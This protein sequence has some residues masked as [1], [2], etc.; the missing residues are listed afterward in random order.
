MNWETPGEEKKPRA[1]RM[2]DG[3]NCYGPVYPC[4]CV[5]VFTILSY[6]GNQFGLVGLFI[7]PEQQIYIL[8]YNI[9]FHQQAT[10]L[11]KQLTLCG[12]TEGVW[13]SHRDQCLVLF[14]LIAWRIH[15]GEIGEINTTSSDNISLAFPQLS[16]G[17]KTQP[18]QQQT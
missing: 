9:S 7:F 14:S 3:R 17:N 2:E 6:I 16:P 11:L 13:G 12:T 8:K 15:I 18:T 10:P 4:V 1:A 5:C